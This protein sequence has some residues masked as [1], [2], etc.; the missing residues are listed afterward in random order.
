[1]LALG[2]IFLLYACSVH[3]PVDEDYFNDI[4]KV[5]GK[6]KPAPPP[7]ID[8][9]TLNGRLVEV[10]FA[11]TATIDPDSGGS[12]NL[13]YL[14]YVSTEDPAGFED[15]RSFYDE[16]YYIGYIEHDRAVTLGKK[17]N[18]LI[19]EEVGEDYH[20]RI[21]FWITAIDEGRESDHS[22]VAAIDV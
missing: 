1:M 9:L 11:S 10:N 14:F 6:N 20:G 18:V 22:N 21:Y 16:Y 3:E 19:D 17:V 4:N 8:G 12:S 7:V 2:T 13:F 5:L 15:P